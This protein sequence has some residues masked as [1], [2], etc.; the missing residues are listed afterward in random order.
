LCVINGTIPIN[1]K[2]E[3]KGIFFEI[4]KGIGTQYDREIDMENWNHPATHVKIIEAYE[5]NSHP[6]QPY[7][8]GSNNDLTVAAGIAIFLD[9]N[10][11]AKLKYRLNGRCTNNHAEQMSILKALEYIQYTETGGKSVVVYT[12]S[13]ITLQLLQNQKTHTYTSHRTNPN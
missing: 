4:T 8:D 2:I 11:T 5:D 7:T 6:I 1:I 9:Y 10:L 12:D 3:K 13:R